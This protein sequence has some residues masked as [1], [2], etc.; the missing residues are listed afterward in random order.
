MKRLAI[1]R[2]ETSIKLNRCVNNLTIREIGP[3]KQIRDI[4]GLCQII[5]IRRRRDLKTKKIAERAKIFHLK[6]LIEKLFKFLN[7]NDII[8]S[9]NHVINI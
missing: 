4:L 5:T 6:V 8:S 3:G 2:S 9:D 7:T 1:I